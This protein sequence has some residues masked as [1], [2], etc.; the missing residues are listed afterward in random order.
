[1]Q[2][3]AFVFIRCEINFQLASF[4]TQYRVS[5]TVSVKY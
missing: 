2:L 3:I 4:K 5:L 1:M